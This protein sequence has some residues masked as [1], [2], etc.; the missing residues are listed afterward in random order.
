M[1]GLA[2]WSISGFRWF[3]N[4]R[5]RLIALS[6]ESKSRQSFLQGITTEALNPKTALFFLSFIPQFVSPAT[7]HVVLQFLIFGAIS[8]ILNTAADLV[9]VGFAGLLTERLAHH[10]RFIERQRT[11]SGAG[12]IG[13]GIYVASS[14]WSKNLRMEHMNKRGAREQSE[15]VCDFLNGNNGGL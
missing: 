8:V 10:P 9:V 6:G 7:G 2:T 12:M 3:R 14:K 15:G 4:R 5:A 13:L 1:L 11:V